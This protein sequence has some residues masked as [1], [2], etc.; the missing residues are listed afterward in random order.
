MAREYSV[1]SRGGRWWV[2]IE[3]Q[4]LGPYVSA[5]AAE[6]AAITSAKLDFKAGQAARVTVETDRAHVVYESSD[7][8]A[9]GETIE[10]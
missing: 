7:V 9:S 8:S 4:R 1:L 5:P 10:R 3:G 2:L 6:M